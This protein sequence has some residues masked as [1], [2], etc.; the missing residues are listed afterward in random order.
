MV[1]AFK[2]F[3][4]GMMSVLT[5]APPPLYRYPYRNS[6]EAFRGD[7]SRIGKDVSTFFDKQQS[8]VHGNDE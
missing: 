7:W 6:G 4:R 1:S 2:E 3:F 5:L 8:T